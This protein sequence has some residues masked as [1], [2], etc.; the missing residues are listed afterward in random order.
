M[1]KLTA[2]PELSIIAGLKGTIDFYVWMGIPVARAWPKSPGH[3]RAP[4]VQAQWPRFTAAARLW[5]QLSPT[6]KEAY[7]QMAAGTAMTAKDIF[8]KTYLTSEVVHL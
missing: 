4:A 5:P 2:L 3:N 6:V 1:A 7:R 8:F